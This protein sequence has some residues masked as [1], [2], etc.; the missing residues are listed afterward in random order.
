ML[1]GTYLD[2]FEKLRVSIDDVQVTLVA[3]IAYNDT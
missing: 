1:A 3:V 2:A